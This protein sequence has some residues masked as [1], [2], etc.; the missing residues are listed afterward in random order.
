MN[1]PTS[2]ELIAAFNFLNDIYNV[3]I[4]RLIKNSSWVT[5]EN[6]SKFNLIDVFNLNEDIDNV[7]IST[8]LQYIK[9]Y[10][11]LAKITKESKSYR[12]DVLSKGYVLYYNIRNIG[13][14][15]FCKST[16][17]TCN[18]EKSCPEWFIKNVSEG[19]YHFGYHPDHDYCSQCIFHSPGF[20]DIT[21]Y[22]C[23][24]N[25]NSSTNLIINYLFNYIKEH[26]IE[27]VVEIMNLKRDIIK[28]FIESKL[29][30]LRAKKQLSLEEKNDE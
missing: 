3:G 2:S 7:D 19:K 25:T 8:A 16:V 14:I 15:R 30:I 11:D 6:I 10:N 20:N 24:V 22:A 18:E 27:D 21:S 26:K 17:T 9:V 4:N 29:L 1:Q 28:Q 13:K 5:D 23:L 12:E